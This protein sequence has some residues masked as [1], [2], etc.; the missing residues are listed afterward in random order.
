[1]IGPSFDKSPLVMKQLN[2]SHLSELQEFISLFE[3][4][5]LLCEGEKGSAK[6]ILKASPPSKD[7]LQDKFILGIYKTE[8]LIGVIDLIQNYPHEN[9]WAI[10][11]LLIHPTCRS[12]GKGQSIIKTL[13][14]IIDAQHGEKLGYI[15]Q[16]QNP[17]ALNL[18][19]K[20]EFYHIDTIQETLGSFQNTTFILEKKL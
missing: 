1:M 16:S 13:T 7:P 12:Q 15:V 2:V 10:G 14:A 3:D 20:C 11:Y 8:K 19:K 18:W 6:G 4:F 9:V 17:R 5:F